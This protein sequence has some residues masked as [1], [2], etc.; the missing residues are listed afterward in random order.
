MTATFHRWA[1]W[2]LATAV[3]VALGAGGVAPELVVAT[4]IAWF[5]SLLLG[6][7]GRDDEA[8][9]TSLP[10][11]ADR[12]AVIRDAMCA[13]LE[14]VG[15]AMVLM[16]G[17]RIVAANAAARGEF[18]AHIVGQD[19]RVALRHPDAVK[20]LYLEDGGTVTIRGLSSNGSLWQLTR[21]RIDE[22]YWTIELLDRSAEADIGRA[23]TDFVANASHELRTPL[24]AIIGY[25]ETLAEDPG[26]VD[27]ET[28]ARFLTIVLREARRMQSL[29]ADLMSLS[30]LEAEKHDLPTERVDLSQLAGRVVGEFPVNALAGRPTGPRVIL[31]RPDEDIGATGDAKQLEQML[32]NL[33]D[34]ALK[35]GD[36]AKPVEVTLARGKRGMAMIAVRDHGVGIAPDHLPHLT[37]R[38]Y[39]TDPGRSR[40]AGGTGLGLAIVKHIV[41]R[42]RGKLDI[43]STMGEGTQVTVHLP[44]AASGAPGKAPGAAAD[45]RPTA[46]GKAGPLTPN[47]NAKAVS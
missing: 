45:S 18:G 22:R 2:A 31:S 42:H 44:F 8:V 29:V 39:R 15:L 4:G 11:Q 6:R 21:Q 14:R 35:Y 9:I 12:D 30:Q 36:S 23:H 19:A 5:G 28:T 33:I 34:N 16:R 46:S 43:S 41:E 26:R 17:H 25:V 20:L 1:P 32:R 27:A 47:T 10:T 24:S 38:F 13:A 40:A 3:L 37:R 7:R